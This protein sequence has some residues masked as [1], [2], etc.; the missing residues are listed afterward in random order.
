MGKFRVFFGH[1]CQ[2]VCQKL[3]KTANSSFF[4]VLAGPMPKNPKF[5]TTSTKKH[6]MSRFCD[7]HWLVQA[8]ASKWIER[9]PKHI[10]SARGICSLPNQPRLCLRAQ[11]AG[12]LRAA[13]SADVFR[14]CATKRGRR[15][16]FFTY[17]HLR[18]PK[19]WE[20]HQ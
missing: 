1:I 8:K 6:T 14:A 17:G 5:I 4:L 13:T 16:R 2:N 3:P 20:V 15:C 9:L 7:F 18:G 12:N 10:N 11:S 19:T